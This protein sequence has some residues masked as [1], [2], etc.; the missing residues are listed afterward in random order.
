MIENCDEVRE[1]FERYLTPVYFS[2]H[3]H[4]QKVMK[5]LTE[6]GMGSDTYGNLGDREQ[7]P[8]PAAMSVR[9]CNV[10]HGRRIDYLAKTVDVSTWAAGKRGDGSEPS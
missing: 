9:D 2:G 4:T 6:P 5:H 7:F 8:D 3:L 10:K 1:L